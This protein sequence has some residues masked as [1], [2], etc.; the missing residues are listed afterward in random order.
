M[1][2]LQSYPPC[3]TSGIAP[4][5]CLRPLSAWTSWGSWCEIMD[6][7]ICTTSWTWTS[8]WVSNDTLYF[9]VAFLDSKPNKWPSKL[10]WQKSFANTKHIYNSH[11]HESWHIQ[12]LTIVANS[13]WRKQNFTMAREKKTN[14]K[15]S[16]SKSHSACRYV[17]LIAA[18]YSN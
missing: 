4:A 7:D 6:N 1:L 15:V 9:A 12:A 17:T 10:D 18:G 3:R 8:K 13:R 5:S 2:T 14:Q 16:L 11:W